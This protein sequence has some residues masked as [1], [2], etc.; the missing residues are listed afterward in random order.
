MRFL[1]APTL[2]FC[3]AIHVGRPIAVFRCPLFAVG[4]LYFGEPMALRIL[5]RLKEDRVYCN[6]SAFHGRNCIFFDL[7]VRQASP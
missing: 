1:L 5:D 6:S 7:N 2:R 3:D 4:L